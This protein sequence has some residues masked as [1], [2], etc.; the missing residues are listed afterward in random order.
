MYH[1]SVIS[2][3]LLL[4][5]LTVN[6]QGLPRAGGPHAGGPHDGGPHVTGDAMQWTEGPGQ[7]GVPPHAGVEPHIGAQYSHGNLTKET[8]TDTKPHVGGLVPHGNRTE[9]PGA[10]EE[11][12]HVNA[13]GKWPGGQERPG[14][15]TEERRGNRTESGEWGS[16]GRGGERK[17]HQEETDRCSCTGRWNP[18][19]NVTG[20]EVKGCPGTNKYIECSG[21]ACSNQTCP[22]GEVWNQTQKACAACPD[23]KQVSTN[24]Q[25]CVCKTGSTMDYKTRSC[26]PCPTG[27]VQEADRCYCKAPLALDI[28]DNACKECPQGSNMTHFQQCACTD[29]TL[30][31]SEDDWACKPC[32]GK[33][34]PETTPTKQPSAKPEER[35]TCTGTNEVFDRRAVKCVACP[36]GTTARN[37]ACKCPDLSQVYS[38]KSLACEC[39]EG[40]TKNPAGTGCVRVPREGHT[41][42]AAN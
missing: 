41:T 31:W 6:A 42:A 10:Q 4:A 39:R 3:L 32:P 1:L 17:P 19:T 16:Q 7:Q 2:C 9:T 22:S 26:G 34:V 20:K 33:W 25:V 28:K 27:S 38:Q 5:A 36:T 29:K 18:C 30:F 13:T 15:E 40:M 21:T 24:Q 11:R 37:N 12:Q 23:G 35:C 14:N 8:G